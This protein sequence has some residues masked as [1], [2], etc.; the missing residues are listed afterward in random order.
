MSLVAAKCP[1]ISQ[2]RSKTIL[3]DFDTSK[4][5]GMW[6]EAAY[7]DIAQVGSKCQTLDFKLGDNGELVC[8]FKV[9]YSFIPFTIVEQ[10]FPKDDQ[11]VGIYTKR[12][13]MP[14]SK[15]VQ[16]PTVI[17]DAILAADGSQYDEL[18]IYA[19][20]DIVGSEKVQEL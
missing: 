7:H 3:N 16:L 1:D 20:D 11:D 4:L 17:V 18:I 19:C 6:Y 2:Y 8:D 5:T 9:D 14:G 10:Y 15:L 13:K 12:V